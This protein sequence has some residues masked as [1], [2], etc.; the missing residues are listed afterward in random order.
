VAVSIILLPADIATTSARVEV[1]ARTFDADK[2]AASASAAKSLTILVKLL[3]E[4]SAAEAVSDNGLKTLA[5]KA[6]AAEEVSAKTLDA[7]NA[8]LSVPVAVSANAFEAEK[9]VIASV[10]LTE[11]TG[12]LVNARVVRAS[13]TA[14]ESALEVLKVSAAESVVVA[15]SGTA[16]SLKNPNSSDT[17]TVSVMTLVKL[18]KNPTSTYPGST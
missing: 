2:A 15:E 3:A 5:T 13:T 4:A 6:S 14:A 9:A 1:S 18:M 16:L 12:A 17:P 10:V 11:S 8:G 7:E